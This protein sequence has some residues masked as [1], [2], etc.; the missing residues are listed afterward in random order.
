V[1]WLRAAAPA[2]STTAGLAEWAAAAV[3]SADLHGDGL[4][5]ATATA[6]GRE[7]VSFYRDGLATGFV[8]A[9]PRLFP[10]ALATSPT[11][12]IARATG[13]RGPTYTLLGGSAAVEAA[14]EHALDDI[15]AGRVLTA[16]VVALDAGTA[17]YELAA[18]AVRR[19]PAPPVPA[20][21]TAAGALSQIVK[22]HERGD[23]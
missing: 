9:N 11:G 18:I 4:Y 12:A 1:T 22:L 6:G 17:G 21:D 20:G 3:V 23:V 10:W 16:L 8:F 5:V 7:S 19:G 13:V 15:D 14:F 2:G